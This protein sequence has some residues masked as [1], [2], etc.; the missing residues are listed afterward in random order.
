[1]MQGHKGEHAEGTVGSTV[2][3]VQTCKQGD[4]KAVCVKGKQWEIRF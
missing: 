1:M 4:G 3:S 2:S